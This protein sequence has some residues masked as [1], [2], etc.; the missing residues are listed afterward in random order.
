MFKIVEPKEEEIRAIRKIIKDSLNKVVSKHY[1]F[2]VIKAIYNFYSVDR[3]KKYEKVFVAKEG[4]KIVGCI[5]Y[6]KNEL[7]MLYPDP[8]F[9]D[10]KY[11]AELLLTFAKNNIKKKGYKYVFGDALDSS[12]NF[13]EKNGWKKEN[14]FYEQLENIKFHVTRITFKFD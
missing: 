13:L 3:I 12:I 9:K 10:K 8:E 11:V 14:E 7:K 4:E 2:K 1:N 5:A 6:K